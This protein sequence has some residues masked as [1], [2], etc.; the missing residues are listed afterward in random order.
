MEAKADSAEL[1]ATEAARVATQGVLARHRTG[2]GRHL[3]AAVARAVVAEAAATVAAAC[4]PPAAAHAAT[5]PQQQPAPQPTQQPRREPARAAT[6]P[7]SP[8]SQRAVP[9]WKKKDGVAAASWLSSQ[10]PSSRGEVEDAGRKLRQTI[11]RV[12]VNLARASGGSARSPA[13]AKPA[14]SAAA[15][16]FSSSQGAA[17]EAAAGA[18]AVADGDETEA[19]PPPLVAQQQHGAAA[20]AGL[21]A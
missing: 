15:A 12:G 10:L 16:T 7:A 4:A 13:V 2:A 5:P 11:G 17:A 8:R 9:P 19:A 18:V 6:G 20:D 14:A 21:V 1:I 3:G